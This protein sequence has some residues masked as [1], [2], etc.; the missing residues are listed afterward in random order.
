[1][2]TMFLTSLHSVVISEPS[3][4]WRCLE[5]REGNEE[6][7]DLVF[8]LSVSNVERRHQELGLS[9]HYYFIRGSRSVDGFNKQTSADLIFDICKDVIG[10]LL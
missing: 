8:V 3:C 9:S 4:A 1:M 6:K 10:C 2:K 5:E 7:Q